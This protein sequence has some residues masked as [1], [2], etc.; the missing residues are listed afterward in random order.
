[1]AVL[2]NVT[3]VY[4]S[5]TRNSLHRTPQE[6]EARR[7]AATPKPSSMM[8]YRPFGGRGECHVNKELWIAWP[9]ALIRLS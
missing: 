9:T 3:P 2:T 6:E 5:N 4:A 1:M 8:S 7:A